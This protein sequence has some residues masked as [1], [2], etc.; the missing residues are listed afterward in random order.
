MGNAERQRLQQSRRAWLRV[1]SQLVPAHVAD[2][3]PGLLAL[4]GS[5]PS[6]NETAL[7]D[8]GKDRRPALERF[9]AFIR[10]E[11]IR[12]ASRDDV[13]RA[14]LRAG[15]ALGMVRRVT[16]RATEV[17]PVLRLPG[18]SRTP[19]GAWVNAH[20]PA[21]GIALRCK[22]VANPT[23]SLALMFAVR[24]GVFESPNAPAEL[25]ADLLVAFLGCNAT[26][27]ENERARLRSVILAQGRAETFAL[28]APACAPAICVAAV[29]TTLCVALVWRTRRVAAKIPWPLIERV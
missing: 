10:A 23:A 27:I 9:V 20:E 8:R 12:G 13:A 4:T 26:A 29:L 19:C 17:V 24:F 14:L 21:P 15:Y 25:C 11:Q 2:A 16:P 1:L 6:R 3:T 28:S 5:A 7:F 18:G 22:R